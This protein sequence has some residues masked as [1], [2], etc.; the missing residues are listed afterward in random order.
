MSPPPLVIGHRG[1]RA[2]FPEN[3]LLSFR[4]AFSAGADGVEC[5]VQKTA[6]G[7]Y[8]V[9]HDGTVDRV[10][11]SRGA[12]NAMTLARLRRVDAG[13]GE[14]I[15]TLEEVLDALP[16]GGW[17]D[18]EL[19]T[20]T[21][22]ADDCG[23]IADILDAHVSRSRLMVSSFEPA[24]LYPMRARGFTVGLL[25]G[26][27]A[28]DLGFLRV[29]RVLLALHP[30]YLNLPLQVVNLFGER[31]ALL[32]MRMLRALGFSLLFWTVND[33]AAARLVAPYAS[34][35]VSDE[36]EVMVRTLRGPAAPGR[37]T[38]GRR[39]APG[40]ATPPRKAARRRSP[41]R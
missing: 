16:P 39:R 9:I 5:D 1:Y 4:S 40:R 26:E 11:H 17:I 19:K 34:M 24:L 18:V 8:V 25:L 29:T 21:L 14:R 20:E 22:G 37:A 30:Q 35:I 33:P 2:R 31:R 3:T 13:R 12:V 38:P 10:S 6:D 41:G 7:S 27:E 36:V 23:P 15:P 28:R 32:F